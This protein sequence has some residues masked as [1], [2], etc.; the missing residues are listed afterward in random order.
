MSSGKNQSKSSLLACYG[1]YIS[2][3]RGTGYLSFRNGDKKKCDFE[4]G[5]LANSRVLLLCKRTTSTI[6]DIDSFFLDRINPVVGFEGTTNKGLHIFTNNQVDSLNYLPETE[7]EGTFDAFTLRDLCVEIVKRDKVEKVNFGITNF[8]FFGTQ[9]K[10]LSDGSAARVLPFQINHNRETIDVVIRPIERYRER[11]LHI[12]T[13][14]SIDVS[15]EAIFDVDDN[16]DIKQLKEVTDNLCYL[17]SVARG[18]KIVWIYCDQYN[19]KD[20]L[21]KREHQTRI[22]K[23]YCP[24]SIIDPR[25]DGMRETKDFIEQTYDNYVAKRESLKL[26]RGTIDAYLDAK[27]ENDYIEMRGVKL[28]V[29]AEILKDRFIQLPQFRNDKCSSEDTTFKNI[30]RK[31]CKQISLKA[32]EEDLTVFIKSRNSLIHTGKFFYVKTANNKSKKFPSQTHEYL[33]LLNF[34]DKLFIKLL[35]Y[36]GIYIEWLEPGNPKRVE[37]T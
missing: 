19:K 34:M 8:K 37:L 13:L 10:S 12:T 5:Q 25:T 36:S 3:Y 20:E 16:I 22:T 4:V 11:I 27:A 15:C 24:L 23:P 9:I 35:G 6:E 18:T 17:F 31:L 14:K 1:D 21:I 2:E 30:L 33:F 29:S 32:S 7:E 28:A 26:N